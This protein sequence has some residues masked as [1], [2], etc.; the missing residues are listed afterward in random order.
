MGAL[1][2]RRPLGWR[3][4]LPVAV[5]GLAL[6]SELAL[7]GSPY[8]LNIILTSVLVGPLVLLWHRRLGAVVLLSASCALCGH[9]RANGLVSGEPAFVGGPLRERTVRGVVEL[10]RRGE[11][12]PGVG[13]A[14]LEVRVAETQERLR[15]PSVGDGIR[16]SVGRSR[17]PW[18]IGD[19][20][21]VRLTPRPVRGFCNG[22]RDRWARW[23]VDRGVQ[24]TAW[25]R[26]DG[27]LTGVGPAPVRSVGGWVRRVRGDIG[28]RIDQ[29][30]GDPA[31][32]VL[33]ALV[34]GDKGRLTPALRETF[35]RTGT[36]HLLA[37]SGMHLAIVASSVVAIARFALAVPRRLALGI[38]LTR[39]AAPAGV[40]AAAAY[41]LLTGGAVSTMR[42]LGMAA[43]VGLG[44]CL[45]RRAV[46][47]RAL[48]FATG[49][50]LLTDPDILRDLS[51]QLSFVSVAAILGL[52]T[53][54]RGT[55]LG[56]AMS[57]GSGS[58]RPR[59]AWAWLVSGVMVSLAAGVGTA[60]LAA[61]YFGMVSLVGVVANLVIGPLLG[62]G[63]LGLG[64]VSA[65]CGPWAPWV[66]RVGFVWAGQ[67]IDLSIAIADWFGTWP[68]AAVP[69]ELP[70][71]ATVLLG[72]AAI[73][74]M[75]LRSRRWRRRAWLACGIVAA[76][77]WLRA[78]TGQMRLAALDVG[79]GDALLLEA[80]G[81]D[82]WVVDAGG[83]GGDFDTGAS[84]V[85]PAVA[86]RRGGSLRAVVL[87]HADRDH[88]GGLAAVI[89]ALRPGEFLWN[90]RPSESRSFQA[91]LEAARRGGAAQVAASA[92][93]RFWDSRGEVELTVV[94][95]PEASASFG[96]NDASLVL[97]ARYGATRILFAGDIEARAERSLVRG[98]A[99]L[100]ATVLKV[101]H[102]A[103]RTSSTAAF[104]RAV[105]PGLAIAS[106][107]TFNRFGF[108]APEVSAR[109]HRAGTRWRAT[110]RWGEVVL[111]SDGQV[112]RV[113]TCRSD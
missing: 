16:V 81:G 92:G 91:L 49:L 69:L 98:G 64:L 62:V 26:D 1:S 93:K 44:L 58:A 90:D 45:R 14:R 78:P 55:A 76:A 5:A 85:V 37:V 71:V 100:A 96:R 108:P 109:Y 107:G 43:V 39:V 110:G 111:V 84:V 68:H 65:L 52:A 89:E 21:E 13:W 74:T 59:K 38:A 27:N 22:G 19:E 86:A 88:Y 17:S 66:G 102:H 77:L 23:L 11:W 97:S 50:L 113:E 35:A 48:L 54:S 36:A 83:L 24:W 41:A 95:P 99:D 15:G 18:E 29:S 53:R 46:S 51:F 47:F 67:L 42:A 79:Q 63:A 105:R 10:V 75:A 28:T 70:G 33:R 20:V 72:L 82:L 103:S 25:V 9:V 106:L 31:A 30:V 87:S 12:A 94:H 60:P 101:P 7:L 32:A 2:R 40:L 4:P 56:S 104:V 80:P 34:L 73:A 6:G 3:L 8:G 57:P 112:E 61:H